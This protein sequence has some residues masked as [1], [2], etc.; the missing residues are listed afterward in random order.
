[1]SD[2]IEALRLNDTELE[3][4][5]R[6]LIPT[7][8][9]YAEHQKSDYKSE[10]FWAKHN[11]KAIRRAYADAQ[12]ERVLDAT[13][14]CTDCDGLGAIKDV[15]DQRIKCTPCAGTGRVTLRTLLERDGGE[16]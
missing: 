9:E 12:M 3:A 7:E 2:R 10:E 15:L 16:K 6:T 14:V 11:G 5:H 1:M 4:V 8:A 13:V